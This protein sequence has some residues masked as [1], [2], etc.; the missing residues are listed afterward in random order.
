MVKVV[1]AWVT[2]L[3]AMST[4]GAVVVMAR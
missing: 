4:T 1:P 2:V 3:A